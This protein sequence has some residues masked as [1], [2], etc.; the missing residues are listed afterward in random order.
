MGVRDD[1]T[2]HGNEGRGEATAAPPGAGDQLERILVDWADGFGRRPGADPAA[3]GLP[4]VSAVVARDGTDERR[5]LIRRFHFDDADTGPDLQTPGDDVL[6]A[7]LHPFRDPAR[8]RHDYPLVLGPVAPGP[9]ERSVTPLGELL[10]TLTRAMGSSPGDTR[11]LEDN[12]PRLER[13]VRETMNGSAPTLDAV[14]VL[15][16]AARTTE[17]ALGLH[18]ESGKRLHDDLAKLLQAMPDGGTLVPLGTQTP[19]CLYLCVAAEHA[20]TRRARL[21]AEVESLRNRLRDLLRLDLATSSEDDPSQ[22]LASS[23]GAGQAYLDPDALSRVVK[24]AGRGTVLPPE[25]RAR[26]GEAIARFDRYLDDP[27]EPLVFVVHHEA[28]P[29][30][31]AQIDV[32]WHAVGPADGCRE[33]SACF[34]RA[35]ARLAPLFGA[36]R[37]ARMELAGTYDATRHD[38]LRHA[39]D[40]RGFAESELLDLP[41]VLVLE[42][43]EALAGAGMIDLSRL[44]RSGR[45]VDIL[46]TVA[47]ALNPGHGPG[48]DP[49]GGYRF[50]LAYLGL[51]HREAMVNQS[52]AARPDHLLTGFRR[53]L[54]GTRASLH[55]VASGLAA[56][57]VDP[58]LGAWFH[59]GAALE[60]RAHP[61][62]HYDPEAGATWARRLDFSTNPQPEADWPTYTLPCRDEN[63]E[64]KDH[65]VAFT[66]AD[67]ALLE[68]GYRRHFRIIPPDVAGEELVPL[69]AYLGLSP[70]Q[71]EDRIPYVEAVD[72]RDHLHRLVISRRLA[73]A[74]RDRL[75]YWH[76]L[77]ELSG[78]R[79][80][81]VR[82]ALD[83]QHEDL[84]AAFAAE[85]DELAATHA[86]A[87]EQ[88]RRDAAGAAMR[89]LA[90]SLLATDV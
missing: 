59:G 75:D 46:V 30:D 55:V 87:L 16:R 25:R 31:C 6:P 62:F 74:C 32:A 77:Q 73:F 53:S 63:G 15:T 36:V 29:D 27:D 49:L 7:L 76:T 70:E 21:R 58:P 72:E 83:R 42:S 11:L 35:A 23:L 80:E 90:E 52:S 34:D 64:R 13:S 51:S 66:F 26:I 5:G 45:P 28:V 39:F 84:N 50:E 41:P 82:E 88:T 81:Y 17:A 47:P 9:G 8:V 85:R 48:D 56:G 3:D 33:G 57:G 37:L 68:P 10:G 18:G 79:N 24:T 54:G 86:A 67:F 65:P 40:W 1:S 78:A 2:T 19:L 22:A 69:A 89:R 43:A 4:I 61:L 38:R 71:A 14:D 44:L 20:G 60:G 12:L